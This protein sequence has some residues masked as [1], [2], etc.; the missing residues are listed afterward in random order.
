MKTRRL[1]GFAALGIVVLMSLAWLFLVMRVIPPIFGQV[2]DAATGEPV[3]GVPVAVK[4]V[5]YEGL[6]GQAILH[7][8]SSTGPGGR[9]AMAPF[10]AW[11]GF[12]LSR[13]G[14]HWMTVNLPREEADGSL[15]ADSQ[16]L[17]NPLSN[18]SGRPVGDRRYFPVTVTFAANQCESQTIWPATCV[19]RRPWSV[20]AIPLIPVYDDVGRC[21]RIGDAALR[22]GCRQLNTYRSAFLHVDTFDE[23]QRALAICADVAVSRVSDFCRRQVDLYAGYPE[24]YGR[25]HPPPGSEPILRGLFPDRIA[26]LTRA[27]Q[28]CDRGGFSQGYLNCTADYTDGLDRISV[29]VEQWIHRGEPPLEKRDLLRGKPVYADILNATVSSQSRPEGTVRTYRG[30]QNTATDWVSGNRYVRVF[31][32]RS[33]R[34]ESV[35]TYY[36]TRF[37][38][39]LH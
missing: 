24:D 33:S 6:G 26:S 4:Y 10:I 29:T 36:L 18:A 27:R 5:R 16:V 28:E 12:P 25:R 1:L 38:S 7:R 21:Q 39:T 13:F 8:I 14:D 34:Q 20:G 22:E 31:S 19:Y 35:T 37:P 3:G 15:S 11:N 2:T 17:S 23:L 9:F 32:E 30:P